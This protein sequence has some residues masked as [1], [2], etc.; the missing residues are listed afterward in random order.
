MQ[1]E[2]SQPL[3]PQH[4]AWGG[5]GGGHSPKEAPS[6]W[7]VPIQEQTPRQHSCP[8]CPEPRSPALP[9]VYDKVA[10][11]PGVPR[12][13]PCP[14]PTSQGGLGREAPHP[15]RAELTTAHNPVKILIL[16]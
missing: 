1:R 5:S 15:W 13:R 9:R 6:C 12:T 4:Q 3:T 16:T 2:G 11:A 10:P 7:A 14:L 8:H